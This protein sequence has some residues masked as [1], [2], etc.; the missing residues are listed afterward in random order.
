MTTTLYLRRLFAVILP[1]LLTTCETADSF[2]SQANL[3]DEPPAIFNLQVEGEIPDYKKVKGTLQ[4]EGED[5]ATTQEIR[6]ERRGGYS[7]GFPKHSYELDLKSDQPLAGLP[8]DDDWI[9]NANY[10]DKTFLRHYLSYELF[11]E[12]N[13]N[14]RAPRCAFVEVNLNG[15]YN[16]L[17]VLM[18]KLDRSVLQVEKEDSAAFI[19]KE[20][21]L[22]REQYDG[23]EPSEKGGFHHQTH[24][25]LNEKDH[26]ATLEELRG[27]SLNAT[28]DEFDEELPKLIDLD[29]FIDW[30]LLLLLTNNGDGFLK[31]FYLYRPN[32]DTRMRVAPWDYDHSFGRDGD[33]ELNLNTRTLA[34]K[35]SV[36]FRRLLQRDWYLEKLEERWKEETTTGVF[37]PERVKERIRQL[38]RQVG[39]AAAKNFTRWPLDAEYYY[40]ANGFEKEVDIMIEFL[41]LRYPFIEKSFI[42]VLD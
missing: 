10:I 23:I 14:N 6:I 36:L 19:F 3:K 29:N 4:I 32:A 5:S 17:Y 39:P 41:D 24:P 42:K 13:P 9:L 40:D 18:E 25:E 22:F 35:R 16:G 27:L 33:N 11:R 1:I 31:N 37:Q 15:T 7:I 28:D 21:H 34:L 8:A 20:P 30:H 38:A 12:M 26:S 2:T